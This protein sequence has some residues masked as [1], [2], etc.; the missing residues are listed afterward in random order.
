MKKPNLSERSDKTQA[1]IFL[2]IY[3]KTVSQVL[4][5]SSFKAV[6]GREDQW[7]WVEK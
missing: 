1:N 5:K 4:G 2:N 6:L 7:E 3:H